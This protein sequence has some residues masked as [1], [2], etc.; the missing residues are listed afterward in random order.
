MQVSCGTNKVGCPI[1]C[2]IGCQSWAM[3]QRSGALSRHSRNRRRCVQFLKLLRGPLK[4][5]WVSA[6]CQRWVSQ[7]CGR[8]LC[9]LLMRLRETLLLQ[10]VRLRFGGCCSS[11]VRF[12]A[13]TPPGVGFAWSHAKTELM[14][15]LKLPGQAADRG[16]RGG[17]DMRAGHA[18]CGLRLPRAASDHW[19]YIES[20]MPAGYLLC[21]WVFLRFLWD[22]LLLESGAP[23]FLSI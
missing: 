4:R 12:C 2:W 1:V 16:A 14:F 13:C 6:L 18:G 22:N 3:V 8:A 5:G 20:D 17:L 10:R 15:V 19:I 21:L 23:I 7:G 11:E 9:G